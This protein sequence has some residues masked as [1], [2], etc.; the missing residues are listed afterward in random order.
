M[1]VLADLD[2]HRD[3]LQRA[4]AGA[5]ADPVDRAL[6]LTRTGQQPGV[7]VGDGQAQVVVAVDRQLDLAQRRH[8][9]VQAPEIIRVLLGRGVADRVGDVDHGR[10]LLDRD[11]ADL[12]GELDVGAGRVHRRELDVLAVGLGQGDRGAGLTL[13]VLAVGLQLVLDVDVGGRDEG[14]DA[15][16]RGVLD[17]SPGG[18]DV[19]LV[20]AGQAADHRALDAAG[21]RLDRLEVAGRGDREAGL[22]HVDAQAGELLGDLDLLRRVQRDSGR[23]L[24]VAQCGVEDVDAVCVGCWCHWVLLLLYF[25]R[26][27][28]SLAAIAPPSAIP[29]EGGG[30]GEA[31][32]CRAGASF[33]RLSL[34]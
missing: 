2:Q 12:G 17:R 13:D 27:T 31:R 6:D 10:A 5:L 4:V 20:G 14:V 1:D 15:R 33:G 9:L 25:S 3:L 11:R 18:V 8:Q 30:E 16:A 23:L 19:G 7:G 21:D 26:M 29:P 32:G 28:L 22:D 34:A 24:A